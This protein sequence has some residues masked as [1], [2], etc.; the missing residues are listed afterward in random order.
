MKAIV[1]KVSNNINE[2]F[3]ILYYMEHAFLFYYKIVKLYQCVL[4]NNTSLCLYKSFLWFKAKV[5]S[6]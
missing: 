1:M 3:K 2:K 4:L 6:S 5:S